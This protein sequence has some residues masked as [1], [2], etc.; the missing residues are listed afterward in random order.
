MKVIYFFLIVFSCNIN[1]QFKTQ[2]NS[3][4]DPTTEV[5]DPLMMKQGLWTYYNNENQIIRQENYLDNELILRKYFSNNIELKIDDLINFQVEEISNLTISNTIHGEAI[6]DEN[7][8]IIQISF[9]I[10]QEKKLIK[11]HKKQILS[12][13]KPLAKELKKAIII[14]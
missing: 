4:G 2:N 10:N 5:I 6:I 1:A 7:G 14:F 9:Y 12:N 3:L 11:K 8:E 13:L